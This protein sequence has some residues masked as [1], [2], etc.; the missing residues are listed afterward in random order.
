VDQLAKQACKEVPQLP[1]ESARGWGSRVHA[2]F[3]E[4]IKAEP[5]SANLFSEV[6]YRHGV[7]GKRWRNPVTRKEGWQKDSRVPDVVFGQ[8]RLKPEL[9]L[10]LKTGAE[11]LDE[12]WYDELLDQLPDGYEN[13]PVLAIRC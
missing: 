1:G 9:L 8:D 11:G 12:T 10:D 4:L 13:V 7:L 2:R 3:A 6:A 5:A